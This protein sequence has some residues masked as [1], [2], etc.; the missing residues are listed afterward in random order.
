MLCVDE[1][2]AMFIKTS[3]RTKATG[4]KYKTHYLVEG[5]RDKKTGTTKHRYISN[6]SS[7]PDNCLL[8]LKTA[9]KGGLTE[10]EKVNLSELQV[11]CNK[12]Y[13]GI[14]LFQK[15]YKKYFGKYFAEEN[16]NKALEAIVINKIFNPKSKNSLKSWM[17]KVDL[18]YEIHNK[19]D[20]YDSLDYLEK[21]RGQVEKR[22]SKAL[23][24]NCS[25]VLYDIT[26]TYFEGKG[27]ENICKY[28]YS[29]DHRRDRVQ[30][31]IGVVTASDGTPV[32]VEI[33]AGNI[34][35]KE[36]LQNQVD[37]IKNKFGIK[38]ITFV[39]DRG[40]KSVV[41]L[42][43]LQESGYDYVTAL[44]HSELRK[45]CKDNQMVQMSLF[46]KRDLS[47]FEIEGK[48]YSLVHNP[49]KKDK[50][51]KSRESLILKTVEKLDKIKQFKRDYSPMALQDKVSK[52]I[53]KYNCGKFINYEIEEVDGVDKRSQK[54][55]CGKLE[56]SIADDK[57]AAA[58]Q[59]D[60]FYMIESSN[61]SIQGKDS[62]SQ[63]KDLQLVERAFNSVKNHIKIRP[64]FHYKESRIKGHIMTCFMSYFL[65]HKLKQG[66]SD[67]LEKHSLDDIL[68]ELTKIQKNYLKIKN[69]FF[70]KITNLSSLGS[71]ILDRFNIHL[72]CAD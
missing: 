24:E 1:Y 41:N 6:L 11:L 66:C 60:G 59:H 13:G 30:V 50:D 21:E 35:D 31:N 55:V 17:E 2:V 68:M 18:G 25:I 36:T 56:Y 44:S 51:T 16:Y 42:K 53:N 49:M 14:K 20:L 64:V 37:K 43:Y 27:S 7:L 46:D 58:E 39:F 5:Y 72:L 4:Q 57:V 8:T 63:Y 29:R 45:L 15:L 12:E 9:L 70:E 22:L 67:L 47:E 26:S 28:G 71:D 40:M 69:V 32:A 33:M 48:Y 19:N 23:R 52:V 54:K 34:S 61:K 3:I 62:V 38:Q 65:L 10:V